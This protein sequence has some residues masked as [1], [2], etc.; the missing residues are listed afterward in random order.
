[1]SD[2]SAA[3]IE[4]R[5]QQLVERRNVER[6]LERVGYIIQVMVAGIIFWAGTAIVELRT[7]TV[8]LTG[9][10]TSAGQISNMALAGVAE[11]LSRI[12]RHIETVDGRLREVERGAH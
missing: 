10:I 2:E 11:R 7:V 6:F 3:E 9:R 8:D 1:V 12:E 5:L 4:R